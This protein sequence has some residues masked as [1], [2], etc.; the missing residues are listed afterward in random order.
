MKV[1]IS[2]LRAGR[3]ACGNTT[4]TKAL[5]NGLMQRQRVELSLV[6][7]SSEI[8]RWADVA[9][10]AA[11]CGVNL[12]PYPFSLLFERVALE[13]IIREQRPD[14]FHSPNNLL[15]FWRPR[16]PTVVSIMDLNY[17]T[18]SQG[19]AKNMYK[20]CLYSYAARHADRIIAI[21]RFT[22]E[23]FVSVHP[24][25]EANTRVVW[26]GQGYS[27][28]ANK[29]G[30]LDLPGSEYSPFLLTVAHRPHKNAEAAIHVLRLA[31]ASN[32]SLKLRVLGEGRC[33]THLRNS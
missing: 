19:L 3:G 21:S 22:A 25:A 26:L 31:R 5:V 27:G 33:C 6:V 7:P 29:P 15:P 30:A 1:L 12:P 23:R 20:K 17:L 14:I 10:G 4:Y 24:R 32:P 18:I 13:N 28:I 11:V 8:G 9:K 16:C 2:A